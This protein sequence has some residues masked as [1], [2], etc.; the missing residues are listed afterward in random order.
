MTRQARHYTCD[1]QQGLQS[2]SS[3][4]I[5]ARGIE[6]ENLFSVIVCCV[7]GYGFTKIMFD[8]V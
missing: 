5:R 4:V 3:V 1:T 6:N 8:L 7:I 2:E